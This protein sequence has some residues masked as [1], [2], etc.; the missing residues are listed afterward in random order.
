[1]PRKKRQFSFLERAL[2]AAGGTA[3]SG[4]LGEFSKFKSGVNKRNAGTIPADARVRLEYGMLPF[5]ND[6]PGTAAD[7]DFYKF[8][9]TKYSNVWRVGSAQLSNAN[10]GYKVVASAMKAVNNFYPAIAHATVATGTPTTKTSG[11]TKQSYKSKTSKSY[12]IPFG[13]HPTNASQ[14][15][16]LEQRAFLQTE[17]T[18]PAKGGATAV[19]FEPEVW[20]SPDKAAAPGT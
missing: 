10:L 14:N 1:M 20:T 15:S 11:I 19:S 2:K 7:A 17:L 9:I 4:I 13:Q 8:T 5:G 16:Y 6:L 18:D 3:T 12:S